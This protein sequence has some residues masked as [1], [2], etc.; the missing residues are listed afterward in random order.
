MPNKRDKPIRAVLDIRALPIEEYRLPTDGR[1]WKSVATQRRSLLLELATYADPDGTLGKYSPE[2]DRL[3]KTGR[4]EKTLYRHL[5]QL[6]ELGLLAWTR[7]GHY[8]KRHYQI[9][10]PLNAGNH[11]PDSEI[12]PVRLEENTCQ[13]RQQHLSDSTES[14]VIFADNTC[15]IHAVRLDQPIANNQESIVGGLPP[16]LPSLPSLPSNT[17]S[18]PSLNSKVVVSEKTAGNGKDTKAAL[19]KV[20]SGARTGILPMI[21]IKSLE[22]LAETDGIDNICQK[23][24]RWLETRNTEGLR[25]PLLIFADECS[26]IDLTPRRDPFV[27]PPEVTRY[28]EQL[29]REARAADAEREEDKRLAALPLF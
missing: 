19:V 1:K 21:G 16:S 20:W 8:G 18:P 25:C 3:L 15:Q 24:K 17:P 12:T 9:L 14:P 22:S 13:I 5:D 23:F 7:E 11:L 10:V 29:E 27:E 28:K 2:M 6:K 26:Q 4:A